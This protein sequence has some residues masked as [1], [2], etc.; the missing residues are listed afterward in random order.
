LREKTGWQSLQFDGEGFLVCPEPHA[1]SG[2]SESARRLLGEAIFSNGG[3]YLEARN[4]SPAVTFARLAPATDYQH[5]GTGARITYHPVQI[6][7]ADFNQLRGHRAALEAFDLGFVILHELAHGVWHL[8]DAESGEQ[9]PGECETFINQIRRELKLPE[10]LNYNATVRN[11]K[12]LIAE[13]RFTRTFES[14]EPGRQRCYL[15]QWDVETV[16]T[17]TVLSK[18]NSPTGSDRIWSCTF[19]PQSP[20]GLQARS[21]LTESERSS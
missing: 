4:G 3:Y 2:G 9:E 12:R 17:I 1:F 14:Q 15:L 10:R 20:R 6:D 18:A 5:H 13:L 7:F 19:F 8:R 16:G 21:S 11:G